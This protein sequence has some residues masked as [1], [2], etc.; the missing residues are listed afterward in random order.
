MI[1]SNIKH[2][3]R[4]AARLLLVLLSNDE[5]ERLEDLPRLIVIAGLKE[6]QYVGAFA[7]LTR[8]GFV[9]IRSGQIVILDE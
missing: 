6:W 9:E 3:S 8:Q 4:N 2:L 7:E 1:R 5:T